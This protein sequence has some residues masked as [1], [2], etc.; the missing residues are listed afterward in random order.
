MRST[1]RYLRGRASVLPAAVD[2]VRPSRPT[3]VGQAIPTLTAVGPAQTRL[4][5][6]GVL[7]NGTGLSATLSGLGDRDTTCAIVGGIVACFV[8]AAGIPAA[9]LHAREPLPDWKT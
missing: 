4:M 1:M 3:V 5:S 6:G 9:W 2:P 7:G 8:G